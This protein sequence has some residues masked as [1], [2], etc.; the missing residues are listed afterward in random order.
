MGMAFHQR[1]WTNVEKDEMCVASILGIV[2]VRIAIE[3]TL[4]GNTRV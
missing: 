2:A 4:N 1:W 3:Q